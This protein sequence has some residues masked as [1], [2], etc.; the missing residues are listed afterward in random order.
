MKVRLRSNGNIG[1]STQFDKSELD[2]LFVSF[3]GISRESIPVYDLD[4][5]LE[6]KGRW[7][8]FVAAIHSQCLVFC[9]APH[10]HFVEP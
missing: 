5:Y 10:K 6:Q 1:E 4:I 2:Y 8:P 3:D 7:M 9:G